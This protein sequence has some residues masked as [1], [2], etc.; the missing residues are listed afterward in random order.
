MGKL[1]KEVITPTG[2]AFVV[3]VVSF[4]FACKCGKRKGKLGVGVSTTPCPVCDRVYIGVEEETDYGSH[5]RAREVEEGTDYGVY[6]IV[7][8]DGE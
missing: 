4:D 5:M 7:R 2:R 3:C 6:E 1:I 8:E